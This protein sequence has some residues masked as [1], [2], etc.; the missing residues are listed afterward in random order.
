M[1][2]YTF[3]K[4]FE[5]SSRFG[6]TKLTIDEFATD[7]TPSQK[8]ENRVNYQRGADYSTSIIKIF[9][10]EPQVNYNRPIGKGNFSALV[11]AT[12]Q[13]HNSNGE[14]ITGSGFATDGLNDLSAATSILVDGTVK[15]IYKYNAAFGRLNYNWQNKYIINLTARRDGSSRFGPENRFHNF[16]SAGGAWIF[17]EESFFQRNLNFLSFGKLKASYGTTGNDQIGDY[18]FLERY[19]SNNPAVPYQGAS[20]IKTD[21][22]TNPHLQWEETR[23]LS[24]GLDLGFVGD[25]FLV[26]AIYGRN[27][28]S[29]QLLPYSLPI[30]TG[31]LTINRNFPA[32]VQNTTWEFSLSAVNVKTK[33]IEWSSSLNLTI[34]QN[35]LIAFPGLANSSYASTLVVGQPLSINKASVSLGIDRNTGL[36]QFAAANGGLTTTPDITKDPY[37]L[38]NVD[39]KFYGGFQNSIS[40]NHF[41]LQAIFQFIKQN[42]KEAYHFGLDVVP[43]GYNK[44]NQPTFVLDRWQKPGDVASIQRYG[45]NFSAVYE[46]FTYANYSDAAYVDASYIRLENLSISYDLSDQLLKRMKM[47]RCSIFLRGQNL[48]TISKTGGLDPENRSFTSLTPLKIYTAGV[49]LG[50]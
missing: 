47:K 14:T 27:R 13:Q 18:S 29:N 1:L 50:L 23:K 21:R 2:G 44:I 41:E 32:T 3:F 5:L 6:Y 36:Y 20:S 7:L 48:L 19:V 8:P 35:K 24:V 39:P 17:S 31:F 15:A 4:G 12:I 28:S 37:V 38:I 30:T 46:P 43:P 40:Y 25:R 33:K 45:K 9:N 49:Q 42:Q 34:P 26:S 22:I 11:G 10:V 16:A